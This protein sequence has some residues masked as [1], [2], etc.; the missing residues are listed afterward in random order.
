MIEQISTSFNELSDKLIGWT[1][2]FVQ[3]LPN[4]V[5]ALL[6]LVLSYFI[7]RYVNKITQKIARRYIEQKSV[8]S[9]I[10]RVAAVIVVLGGLFLALG[11][12]DLGKTLNTL[13]TGAGISGLVIGLALQGTL[14]N[15][16]AGIVL[17]IRK[18]IRLGDWIETN[19][20]SG[21]VMDIKLNN[22]VLKEADN[23]MV[24]IPNKSIIEN[25]FKN[26]TLTTR[27]R[28]MIEC[29]VGYESDLERV[30]N[31]VKETI[32]KTFDQVESSEEVE[33]FY[34]SYGNS[35]INF[36]CRYWVESESGI[37]KLRAKSKGI[38]EIKKAFDREGINIPFPIRT[39]QFD[40]RLAIKNGLNNEAISAN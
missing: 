20:F 1:T 5:V 33:F 31:L 10:G 36:L 15:M 16:I 32:A 9:L 8:T 34:T 29:G 40:N 2:T 13:L 35:S 39:L 3:H 11:V 22:F 27:M 19:G 37:E 24:I 18:N 26:Y 21:E 17:S 6:V 28:I 38:I 7:G 12:L 14:S 25:P 30:E 4:L 23:N